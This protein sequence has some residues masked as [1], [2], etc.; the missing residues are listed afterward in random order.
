[1]LFKP[2]RADGRS[3]KE[4]AVDFL[5]DQPP[6]TIISYKKLET[7]LDLEAKPDAK[8]RVQAIV[9]DALKQLLGLHQ[10]GVKCVPTVGYRVLL[11]KEHVAVSDTHRSKADRAIDRAIGFLDGANRLEM[12]DLEKKLHDGQL[13]I[14]V[15][16]Q[17]SHHH[18][19]DRL[20]KL[21]R[22]LKGGKTIEPDAG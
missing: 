6:E 18:L 12:S 11:A 5:K 14:M 2:T 8:Q 13:M 7:V 20:N 1:M 22:L 10:R 4:V 21:E 9:R 15:A 19:D 17:A 3:Y 16:L